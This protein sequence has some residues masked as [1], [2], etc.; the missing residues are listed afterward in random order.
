MPTHGDED[1]LDDRGSG[2]D[3]NNVGDQ[4]TY[5]RSNLGQCMLWTF[6]STPNKAKIAKVKLMSNML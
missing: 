6:F 2:K 4:N 3:G 5:Y 1:G